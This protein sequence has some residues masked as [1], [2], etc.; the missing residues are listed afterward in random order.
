MT[1]HIITHH[2]S[3]TAWFEIQKR[4]ILKYTDPE[5]TPYKLYLAKYNIDMPEDFDLPDNWEIIDLDEIYPSECGNEHYL[6]MQ[7]IYENCV[8]D[9]AKDDEMIIFLDSDAFPCRYEWVK[10]I[11]VGITGQNNQFGIPLPDDYEPV[12]AAVIH[13]TENR[14][15]REP[16]EYHPYP[17]LCFFA[18]MKKTWD[19]NNLKWTL[20]KNNPRHQNP[21]FAM[22]E[23]IAEAELRVGAIERTNKFNAHN[24]M[25][26]VYGG[27][28]YHQHCG[29]RAII[30]RPLDTEQSEVE[31]S[32]HCFTGIDLLNRMEIGNWHYD[33]FIEECGDIVEVNTQIFDIIYDRLYN[34]QNCNFV[35]RY[36]LGLP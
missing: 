16:D 20:D 13:F 33:S 4:H 18:I 12:H 9:K 17:D 2:Y 10:D 3:T 22:K 28:L 29:S 8:K 15:I 26:G 6:Q 25:F 34:D 32:R 23:Q 14:G 35:R 1:T 7:W 27:F 5:L 36:F 31:N 19:E 21:G 24:V 30:G 11:L